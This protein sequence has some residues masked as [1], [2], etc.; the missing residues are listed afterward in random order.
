MSQ[1]KGIFILKISQDAA[2][3]DYTHDPWHMR[4][5]CSQYRFDYQPTDDHQVADTKISVS[6]LTRLE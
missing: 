6:L 3:P 2:N 5:G 1:V 4:V